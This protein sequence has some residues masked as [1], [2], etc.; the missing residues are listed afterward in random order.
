M[1][2]FVP[3][4]QCGRHIRA[5]DVTRGWL[6]SGHLRTSHAEVLSTQGRAE[7]VALIFQAIC[8]LQWIVT[9]SFIHS[10]ADRFGRLKSHGATSHTSTVRKH[11]WSDNFLSWYFML[12]WLHELL[13]FCSS[14]FICWILLLTLSYGLI[15]ADVI[16]SCLQSRD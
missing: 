6:R 12:Q 9:T 2:T 3:N 16:P 10:C 8:C 11:M 15:D 7:K 4:L 13:Y 1:E 5:A 14:A